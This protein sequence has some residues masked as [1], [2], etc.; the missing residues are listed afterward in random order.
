MAEL[1]RT[2]IHVSSCS[3][4]YF[5][6]YDSCS[7]KSQTEPP[8]SETYR[9][10][11][12]TST[13]TNCKSSRIKLRQQGDS[14]KHPVFTRI[15]SLSS[16][17][18]VNYCSHVT[19]T[20]EGILSVKVELPDEISL[21]HSASFRPIRAQQRRRGLQ[22]N[23]P[24]SQASCVAAWGQLLCDNCC[25]SLFRG[26]TSLLLWAGPEKSDRLNRRSPEVDL[27]QEGRSSLKYRSGSR[28]FTEHGDFIPPDPDTEHVPLEVEGLCS[29]IT[30]K[31]WTARQDLIFIYWDT[32][33]LSAFIIN[34]L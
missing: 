26:E 9:L 21:T 6:F 24:H 8:V 25:G 18:E 1:S 27:Q 20:R 34:L 30:C 5:W 33:Q 12:T 28:L 14:V 11:K 10:V 13:R 19:K 31:N 2:L 3:R 7:L 29:V 32:L 17:Q 16:H 22:T 23:V 4:F 15:S